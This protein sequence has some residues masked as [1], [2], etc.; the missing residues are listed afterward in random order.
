[1]LIFQVHTCSKMFKC[2]NVQNYFYFLT[3]FTAEARLF[4]MYVNRVQ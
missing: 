2:F 3:L 1:M 4:T